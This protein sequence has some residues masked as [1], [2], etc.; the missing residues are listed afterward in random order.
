VLSAVKKAPPSLKA[1][2]RVVSVSNGP[3]AGGWQR[4]ESRRARKQRLKEL[5]GPRRP[6]P[7]NLRGRCFNCFSPSHRAAACREGTRCFKCH[8]TGHRASCCVRGGQALASVEPRG[9]LVWRPK[10]PKAAVEAMK[11]AAGG[12][13][14]GAADGQGMQQRRRRRRRSRKRRRSEAADQGGPPSQADDD[15]GESPEASAAAGDQVPSAGTPVRHRRI[16]D[17]SA[18]MAR[19]EEELSKALSVLIVV[20]DSANLSVDVLVAELARHYELP[21]EALEFHLLK[22]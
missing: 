1:L 19:A 4:Y 21:I 17:R 14:S 7:V 2:T 5:R 11:S 22:F 9:F 12:E 10:A 18:R 16:I 3:D 6:V 8:Q 13:C 20:D 15:S